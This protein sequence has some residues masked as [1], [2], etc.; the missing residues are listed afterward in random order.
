M[1]LAL[2]LLDLVIF[3]LV[4]DEMHVRVLQ[5][6]REHFHCQDCGICRYVFTT[7]SKKIT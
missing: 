2:L 4:V 7:P 1:L 3:D 6:D 5:V